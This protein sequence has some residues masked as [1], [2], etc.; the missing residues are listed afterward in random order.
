MLAHLLGIVGLFVAPLVIMLV[1][2]PRSAFVERHAKE[3]LNFQIIMTIA[4][5]VSFLLTSMCIGFPML[6]LAGITNLILCIIAG[7]E[8]NKGKDYRYPFNYPFV[9]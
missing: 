2:G 9:K 6:M 3:A 7:L 5:T 4:V 1:F 8:A